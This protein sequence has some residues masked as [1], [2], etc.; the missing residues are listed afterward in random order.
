LPPAGIVLANPPRALPTA[1]V[2]AARRGAFTAS[3]RF[4]PMLAKVIAHAPTRREAALK[5]A[6]ALERTLIGGVVT[7]RDFLVATL[8]HDA[9]LAGDT[10]TDFIERHAPAGRRSVS[11][12][13][14]ATA[15][16]AVAL[17]QQARN[18][19]AATVLTTLPSGF[20]V[21]AVP[22]QRLELADGIV[23]YA[24]SRDGSFDVSFDGASHRAVV[25]A[26]PAGGID[27][28]IDGHRVH[29]SVAA[30]DGR[31]L[32]HLPSGAVELTALER[33]PRPESDGPAGGLVAPMPG[34]I[35]D[36]RAAVGDAVTA[37]QVLVVMEAMKM[38]HHLSTPDGGVVREVRVAV[39]DQVDNGAVVLVVEAS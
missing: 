34:R 18:R 9:F 39:G 2:F 14:R 32:V 10:T 30:L 20:R 35:T 26:A 15:A 7:N 29:A 33:F 36:V 38:E 28:A 17:W 6:L 24:R 19:A 8:R 13:E 27:V 16:I 21:S 5:L 11:A 23:A 22:P 25:L 31:Y 12:H 37:G 4:D 3:G 1:D